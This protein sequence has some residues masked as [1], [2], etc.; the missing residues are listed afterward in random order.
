VVSTYQAI[1]GAGGRAL[2]ELGDQTRAAAAGR[3]LVAEALPY[4][5]FG[6]LLFHDVTDPDGATKEE[7]KMVRETRRILG[8][9]NLAVAAT[10]VRVPVAV[11]HAEAVWV[12]LERPLSVEGARALLSAAPGIEI[13][14]DPAHRV[15]PRPDQSAGRDPVFVGRLRADPSVPNGL[16]MWVVADNLRKGAALNAVQVAEL[17]AAQG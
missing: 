16:A 8:L 7:G 3:P 13:M 12:E 9:P 5:A 1:S 14:D 15:Y 11:G 6:S 10:C 4:P 2:A 17:V